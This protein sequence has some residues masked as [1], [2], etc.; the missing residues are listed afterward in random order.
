[1]IDTAQNPIDLGEVVA[2][3]TPSVTYSFR[4]PKHGAYALFT[5]N[6]ATGELS[7]NCDWGSWSCRWPIGCQGAHSDGRL[8]TLTEFLAE[9]GSVRYI[10]DKL[11]PRDVS[12]AISPELTRQE[13][14]RHVL[15]RR[16]EQ[17]INK[18][19][20]RWAWD[21]GIDEFVDK[22]HPQMSWDAVYALDDL[23]TQDLLDALDI[24]HYD[25]SNVVITDRTFAYRVMVEVLVPTF[26]RYLKEKED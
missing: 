12:T 5:V 13:M 9:R 2:T 8:R 24:Q 17:R 3:T 14:Q 19:A 20:A 21:S 18:D 7:V 23:E 6:D 4:F 11:M 16:R 15:R 26:Q 1:M 25:L 10:V 22:L